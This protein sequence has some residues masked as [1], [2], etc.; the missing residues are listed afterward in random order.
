MALEICDYCGHNSSSAALICWR[1]TSG[2]NSMNSSIEV[3][4]ANSS[5]KDLI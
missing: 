4:D 1:D 3:P 2:Y 5:S